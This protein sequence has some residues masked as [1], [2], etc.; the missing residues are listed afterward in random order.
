VNPQPA[1]F[2]DR[3]GTLIEDRGHLRSPDEVMFYP[4]TVPALRRLQPHFRLFIVTN[5][6]GV[7][8]RE[9]TLAEVQR[10]NDHVASRLREAGIEITAVYCCPHQRS[11]DCACIK[12]K[13]FFLEQAVREHGVDLRR[14]FAVGDHP[15]DVHFARNAGATGIFVLTGHGAMHRDEMDAGDIVAKDIEEATGIILRLHSERNHAATH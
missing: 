15:H 3:D 7:S 9:V 13:P 12:P 4:A 2:L 10:V 5:Q 1:I 8:T 14:S 6:S 11:D